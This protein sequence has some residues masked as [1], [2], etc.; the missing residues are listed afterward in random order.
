MNQTSLSATIL[1]AFVTIAVAQFDGSRTNYSVSIGRKCVTVRSCCGNSTCSLTY[2]MSG[3]WSTSLDVKQTPQECQ[4]QCSFHLK[5]C[6]SKCSCTMRTLEVS[7]ST[8]CKC[9]RSVFPSQTILLNSCKKACHLAFRKCYSR[10]ISN[11]C[12]SAFTALNWKE[13]TPGKC[14]RKKCGLLPTTIC[15][16]ATAK[17][18]LPLDIEN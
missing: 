6:T 13:T 5:K 10:C 15:A 9:V 2:S 14:E 17:A 11:K 18:A 16:I 7:S 12:V 8:Y 1:L 4:K 3:S